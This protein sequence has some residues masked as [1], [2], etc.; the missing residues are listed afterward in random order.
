MRFRSSSVSLGNRTANTLPLIQDTLASVRH[1]GACPSFKRKVI[2]MQPPIAGSV[3][4]MILQPVFDRSFSAPVD[5]MNLA[6]SV[7]V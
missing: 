1:S 3:V 6:P 2:V 5:V 4:P 7:L